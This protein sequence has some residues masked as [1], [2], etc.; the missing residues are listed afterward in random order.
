MPD[1][2]AD[3]SSDNNRHDESVDVTVPDQQPHDDAAK[4]HRDDNQDAEIKNL[5]WRERGLFWIAAFGIFVAFTSM[6]VAARQWIVMEDQLTLM[7]EQLTDARAG[8]KAAQD[9]TTK[10]LNDFSNQAD[11]LYDLADANE[12]IADAAQTSA[13]AAK[14]QGRHMTQQVGLMRDQLADA[15]KASARAAED[16]D[17]QLAI[18]EGQAAEAQILANATKDVADT[19]KA[20]VSQSYRNMAVLEQT[21]HVDQRAWIS[22]TM[23]IGN[24][25][26]FPWAGWPRQFTVEF[27]N[28]GR[29]PAH[30][31][32]S[33]AVGEM[34]SNKSIEKI[35]KSGHPLFEY[36]KERLSTYGYLAPGNAFTYPLKIKAVEGHDKAVAL[37]V[38]GYTTYDDIFGDAHW[39]RFCFAYT[40]GTLEVCG[41]HNDD[42]SQVSGWP[43]LFERMQT[44]P[45]PNY[46]PDI[47][48]PPPP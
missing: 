17:R 41:A 28:T 30:N 10:A 18:A 44:A 38:H 7:Q 25:L 46:P 40:P 32:S 20:S 3:D 14:E 16:T 33:V 6:I 34:L 11:A 15:R 42:D 31:V 22:A 24:R 29:T 1:D 48:Q 26:I 5:R 19:S 45:R 21:L 4:K 12:V 36:S 47:I 13:D 27:K 39:L 8:S 37:V 2:A 43:L 35:G 9:N 23:S